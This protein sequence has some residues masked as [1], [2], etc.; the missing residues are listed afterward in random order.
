MA[1]FTFAIVKGLVKL[2]LSTG[3]KAL[4]RRLLTPGLSILVDLK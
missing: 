4:K 3:L 2:L 1:S